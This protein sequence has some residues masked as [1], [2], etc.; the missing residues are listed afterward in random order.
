MPLSFMA[1]IFGMNAPELSSDGLM[2]LNT[3]LKYMGKQSLLLD[4]LSIDKDKKVC[5]A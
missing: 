4:S 3:Q 1:S 5:Q 2:P